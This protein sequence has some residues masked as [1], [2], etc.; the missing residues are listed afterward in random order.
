MDV[1]R[2]IM[3]KDNDPGISLQNQFLLDR[4]IRFVDFRNNERL[5]DF[6]CGQGMFLRRFALSGEACGLD[7]SDECLAIA[8]RDGVRNVGAFVFDDTS[9]LPFPDAFF[10]VVFCFHVLEHFKPQQHDRLLLEFHRVLRANGR[11]VVGVPIFGAVA[12]MIYLPRHILNAA[13]RDHF[14]SIVH[15]TR[16]SRNALF[17]TVLKSGFVFEGKCLRN[18][19]SQDKIPFSMPWIYSLGFHAPFCLD[20]VTEFRKP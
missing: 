12:A 6:G 9:R 7:M 2:F 8:I 17:K 19:V 15:Q 11:F 1:R 13:V 14:G 4:V 20:L 18:I 10:D 3:K 5:L 16:F